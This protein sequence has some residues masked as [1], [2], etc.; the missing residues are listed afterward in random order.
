MEARWGVQRFWMTLVCCVFVTVPGLSP[1]AKIVGVKDDFLFSD[2]AR[3]QAVQVGQE[4]QEQLDV[5]VLV[6]TFRE[7]PVS[8]RAPLQRKKVQAMG[9]QERQAFFADLARKQIKAHFPKS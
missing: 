4:I 2:S 1:A 3:K 7:V 6:E 5:A 9:A 8:L